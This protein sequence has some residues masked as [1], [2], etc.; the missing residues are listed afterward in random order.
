MQ[1]A[2]HINVNELHLN[3]RIELK[4]LRIFKT[5]TYEKPAKQFDGQLY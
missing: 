1:K 3:D 2:L 5:H 4:S